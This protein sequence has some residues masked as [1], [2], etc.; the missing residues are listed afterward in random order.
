MAEWPG[1]MGA[2]R[3][4]D[5]AASR[6]GGLRHLHARECCRETGVGAPLLRRAQ[7][8]GTGGPGC[9]PRTD[10]VHGDEPS[11][12]P[13][14]PGGPDSEPR[15]HPPLHHPSERLGA[16]AVTGAGP[17]DRGDPAASLC[18]GGGHGAGELL[19]VGG[20]VRPGP[21]PERDPGLPGVPGVDGRGPPSHPLLPLHAR[22]QASCQHLLHR[23][24]GRGRADVLR[25]HAPERDPFVD[26]GAER[27]L[28][29][30]GPGLHGRDLRVLPALGQSP[31][32]AS[33]A[34]PAEAGPGLRCRDAAGHPEPGGPGLQGAR[35]HRELV[36]RTAPD[37]AG[38]GPD[39]GRP[40]GSHGG[41]E[42][43]L[44]AGAG[45]ADFRAGETPVSPAQRPRWGPG[46]FRDAVGHVVHGRTHDAAAAAGPG[47]TGS[48]GCRDPRT[49]CDG[50]DGGGALGGDDRGGSAE[51]LDGHGSSHGLPLG[52]ACCIRC[53]RHVHARLFRSDPP[54]SSPRDPGVL[55]GPHPRGGEVPVRAGPR[56]LLRCHV[57]E[58]PR[59]RRRSP[60]RPGASSLRCRAD[61]GQLG[62]GGRG[63]PGSGP[64]GGRAAGRHRLRGAAR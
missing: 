25:G 49:R 26:A 48:G 40:P 33:D 20:P 12:T 11:R 45:S 43:P 54:P 34:D 38:Q 52:G 47:G 13:W 41:L 29:P 3:G 8:R 24:P 61:A 55:P 28:E 16:W 51:P 18:P 15:A 21:A 19:P 36:H 53:V 50:R 22:G 17:P 39:H 10:P 1:R 64:P 5:P 9:P 58:R 44:E 56:R 57:P 2:G 4:P 14:H 37:R 23:P 46:P 27:D 7:S 31:F 60:R 6:G 30:S 32:Q 62:P 42:S 35:K 63:G 59:R